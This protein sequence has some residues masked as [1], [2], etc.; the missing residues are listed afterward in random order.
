MG[1]IITGSDINKAF[2]QTA[3]MPVIMLTPYPRLLPENRENVS[4]NFVTKTL[5]LQ[6][7]SDADTLVD[8]ERH[9]P[10][11][12]RLDRVEADDERHERDDRFSGHAHEERGDGQ[13]GRD[14]DQDHGSHAA[15]KA[16]DRLLAGLLSAAV[17]VA[18][19][20]DEG[21]GRDEVHQ[22]AVE[23]ALRADRQA[24]DDR[25]DEG[26]E[27]TGERAERERTD[28]DR[29]VRRVVL[30]EGHRGE[31]REVDQRH[32]DD[33]DG[34]QHAHLGQLDGGFLGVHCSIVVHG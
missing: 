6:S 4:L 29:D 15:Q 18:R 32:Q 20:E 26:Q 14:H 27:Q 1:S 11:D 24:L 30:E 5:A 3:R 16:D 23:A 2:F 25:C 28:E 21:A 17:D 19:D 9:Q 8:E 13:V 12:A 31:D 33:R 22:D 10:V 34:D 7:H